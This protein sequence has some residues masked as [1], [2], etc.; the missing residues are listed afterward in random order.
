MKYQVI[1]KWTVQIISLFYIWFYK[2]IYKRKGIFSHYMIRTPTTTIRRAH[3]HDT[4]RWS[5]TVSIYERSMK[6]TYSVVNELDLE[7]AWINWLCRLEED[8][9]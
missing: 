1:T 4:S 5:K 2:E 6:Q 7:N 8:C 3:F 9:D